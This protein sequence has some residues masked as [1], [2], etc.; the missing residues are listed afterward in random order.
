MLTRTYTS[1]L[2]S[3]ILDK[4]DVFDPKLAYLI[5]QNT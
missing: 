2:M 4:E 1:R 5:D 3:E